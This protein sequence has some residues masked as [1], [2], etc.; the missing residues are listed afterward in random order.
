M[1]YL[2]TLRHTHR[3]PNGSACI[4]RATRSNQ[5][6]AMCIS[7]VT[8]AFTAAFTSGR[9]YSRSRTASVAAT[10]S[11]LSVSDRTSE[12]CTA[13]GSKL[14]SS[15]RRLPDG[16]SRPSVSDTKSLIASEKRLRSTTMISSRLKYSRTNSPNTDAPRPKSRM[17]LLSVC[18]SDRRTSS[19]S[20]RSMSVRNRRS[21]RGSMLPYTAMHRSTNSSSPPMPSTR[22][23][24]RRV[25][26]DR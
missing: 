12:L 26:V 7:R 17:N 18:A 5:S 2:S 24:R 8:R 21:F 3:T 11:S 1:T 23:L 15:A 22:V 20:T 16:P 6:C 19:T 9:S 13:T 14:R 25:S 10:S 4:D